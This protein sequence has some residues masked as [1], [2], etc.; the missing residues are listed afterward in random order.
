MSGPDQ[1][2]R[3]AKINFN[4]LSITERAVCDKETLVNV[5][6]KKVKD[7]TSKAD[8]GSQSEYI[9]VTILVA[10][11]GLYKLPTVDDSSTLKQELQNLKSL[12]SNNILSVEVLWTPQEEDDNLSE[13]QLL[14]KY[15]L[16]K[17]FKDYPFVK[18]TL[19]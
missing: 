9:A 12:P 13:L 6:N 1:T 7:S 5:N 3:E 11:R 18:I 14:K 19:E 16:L 17:P 2:I 15:P 8:T 4:Q 10:T